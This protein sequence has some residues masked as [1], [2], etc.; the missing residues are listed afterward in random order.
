MRIRK[1]SIPENIV[2]SLFCPLS[3]VYV[4]ELWTKGGGG[5]GGNPKID[6]QIADP[7]RIGK[8]HIVSIS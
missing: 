1:K 6:R 3:V 2:C 5:G 7:S 8:A 4:V